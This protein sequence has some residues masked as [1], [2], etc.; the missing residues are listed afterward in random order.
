MESL[1]ALKRAFWCSSHRFVPWAAGLPKNRTPSNM[2]ETL[3]FIPCDTYH[4]KKRAVFR[5]T[6]LGKNGPELW[7]LSCFE[8]KVGEYA[9]SIARV[10]QGQKSVHQAKIARTSSLAVADTMAL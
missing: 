10:E 1:E 2:G 9:M 5:V 8:E 4:C 7:C 6:R 3:V